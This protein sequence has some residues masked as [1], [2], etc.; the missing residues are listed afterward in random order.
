MRYAIILHTLLK[1]QVTETLP[2]RTAGSRKDGYSFRG[3]GFAPPDGKIVPAD[4]YCS[5]RGPSGFLERPH[6]TSG[7]ERVSQLR[8]T[9]R[10]R[11]FGVRELLQIGRQRSIR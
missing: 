5:R 6:V 7:C 1:T 8:R 10:V 11:A 2:L 9:E 3:S 4:L